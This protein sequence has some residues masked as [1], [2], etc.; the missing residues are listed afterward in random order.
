[1]YITPNT[2]VRLLTGVP[3]DTTYSHTIYFANKSAQ[4][5]Y[6][7]SK[8]KGGCMFGN[9]SYQ[10]HTKGSIRLQ[11]SADDIYDCNYMMFQNTSF[12][13]K[14]FYAFITSIEY[15]SNVVCEIQ[16][17]IDDM[18]TW[19]FEVKLLDSFVER[20]HSATDVAGD[21]IVPEPVNIGEYFISQINQTT[22]FDDFCCILVSPYK[23]VQS[24]IGTEYLW[25]NIQG[26]IPVPPTV[27]QHQMTCLFY[28]VVKSASDMGQFLYELT[29]QGKAESIVSIYCVPSDFVSTYNSGQVLQ[30]TPATK[31]YQYYSTKPTTL[32]SY[33]PKNKK[34]LT[35]PYNKFVISTNDGNQRDYAFEWFT[36]DS[37]VRFNIYANLMENASFKAVPVNYKDRAFNYEES[38]MLT[39][40]PLTG[41]ITDSFKAWLAQNKTRLAMQTASSIAEG[42]IG[43]IA[44]GSQ[45]LTPVTKVLSKKGAEMMSKGYEQLGK[46]GARGVGGVITD[47]ISHS[48]NRYHAQGS[49]D[50]SLEMSMQKKDFCGYQYYVNPRNAEIIDDFFNVYGYATHR[51][52]KPNRN[53]RPHW[54][55]VK[56]VDI[57]VE[58][59]A[60]ADAVAHICSIYD[61]GITFWK[62][63][64]EVGNYSLN[65]SPT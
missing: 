41:Y 23:R 32:G 44:A 38:A 54:T 49:A 58:G 5:Q 37:G 27:I 59:D 6:F 16:Y 2:V 19:F 13:D 57:N 53:V 22:L 26:E 50:G 9:Q 3:L 60:P 63:P 65:N 1:M 36:G 4:T 33:T 18:Q 34:L 40:F 8:T 43:D 21:N 47:I 20:E 17:E 39:D 62:N 30:G 42:G 29:D 48:V 56:T 24:T 35:Y 25:L 11:K 61:E 64:S 15:V 55:Y 12:G 28:T 7:V 51:V 14:W 52:K 45:M 10:R 31:S 46:Q